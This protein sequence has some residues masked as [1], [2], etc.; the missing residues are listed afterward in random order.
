MTYDWSFD[1]KSHT[2]GWKED[3]LISIS[4][5]ERALST[6]DGAIEVT[7]VQIVI[8]DSDGLIRDLLVNE[9]TEYWDGREG[10]ICLASDDLLI[11]NPENPWILFRGR[12]EGMPTLLADRQVGFTLIDVIGSEFSAFNL[13]KDLAIPI[14]DEHEN[15]PDGLIAY[16]NQPVGEHND[17][18]ATDINGTACDKA[19]VPGV[20]VGMYDNGEPGAPAPAEPTMVSPP[21][22]LQSDVVGGGSKTYK[23]AAS[24]ITPYGESQISE[25]LTV[26]DCPDDSELGLSDYVKL[27]CDFDAGPNHENKVRWWGRYTD[28]PTGWVDESF[29]GYGEGDDQPDRAYY[30]DGSHPAPNPTRVD[31]DRVKKMALPVGTG[32]IA[33]VVDTVWGMVVIAIGEVEVIGR[34]YASNLAEEAAPVREE[35]DASLE[36]SEF[37]LPSSPQWPHPTPYL[38]KTNSAGETIRFTACYMRGARL[39]HHIEGAVTIAFNVCGYKGTNGA[40]VNQAFYQLQM[41]LNEF[42]LKNFGKGYRSGTFGVPLETFL[43]GNPILWTRKFQEAQDTSM[44]LTGDAVGF[45]G[46]WNINEPTTLREFLRRFLVT[47][48]ARFGINHFGQPFVVL[49]TTTVPITQGRLYRYPEE[50]ERVPLSQPEPM[51]RQNKATF[52]FDWDSDARVYRFTGYEANHDYSQTAHG[53]QGVKRVYETETKQLFCTR[54]L[55]TATAAMGNFLTVYRKTPVRVTLE[56]LDFTGLHDELGDRVRAFH[57]NTV[58]P[59]ENTQILIDRHIVNVMPGTESVTLIGMDMNR[60]V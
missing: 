5:I 28:P 44:L 26:E 24:V 11:A 49:P 51:Q 27:R 56:P 54:H 37:I 8:D 30:N 29:Y 3:R 50:L 31:V 23:Y 1:P 6:P 9:E 52:E 33:P 7:R 47:F 25:V 20:Y 35:M 17:T 15:L 16:Y 12:I 57:W 13:E 19:L 2:G 42:V 21:T 53:I 41:Y 22:N 34:P 48:G 46:A 58:R 32:G 18:G 10:D 45:E 59:S 38:E 39:Q 43:D 4:N 40:L 55:V 60:V 36:G 14:G